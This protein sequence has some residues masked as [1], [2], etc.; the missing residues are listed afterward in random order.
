M[1]ISTED[2]TLRQLNQDPE[3]K[4]AN[5]FNVALAEEYSG[6]S[7]YLEIKVDGEIQNFL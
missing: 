3:N 2:A 7:R 6:F 1:N 4:K 5:D